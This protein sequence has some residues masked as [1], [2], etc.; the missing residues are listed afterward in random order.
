MKLPAHA[1]ATAPIRS[2][3][4]DSAAYSW[5]DPASFLDFLIGNVFLFIGLGSEAF[6]DVFGGW[7]A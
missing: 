2:S 4:T 1:P 5:I 3:R 7:Q 6:I